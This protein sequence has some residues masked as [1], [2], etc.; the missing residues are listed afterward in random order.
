MGIK[1][2][3][4]RETTKTELRDVEKKKE[5]RAAGHMKHGSRKDSTVGGGLKERGR[6]CGEKQ[7]KKFRL[8]K[9]MSQ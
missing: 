5:G 9:R 3:T 8:S 1:Y 6:S 2:E 4:R 7:Q